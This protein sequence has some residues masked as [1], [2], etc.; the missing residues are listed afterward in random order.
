[1]P[2]L[3]WSVPALQDVARL[4]AFLAPKNP[5]A[6]RRAIQ[7][8]RQGVKPLS[9]FP[10]AGRPIEGMLPGFRERVIPFGQRAYVAMYYADEHQVTILA[11]R[12]GLEGGY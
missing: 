5:D 9:K 4:K 11:V 8:I 1:M 7:A 3:I 10:E 6:A 12:H 2:R